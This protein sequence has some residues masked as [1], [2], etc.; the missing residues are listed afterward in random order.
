MVIVDI[1]MWHGP[2]RHAQTQSQPSRLGFFGRIRRFL[3]G[4]RNVADL[5]DDELQR[6]ATILNATPRRCLGYRTPNEAFQHQL[7]ALPQA[8]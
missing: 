3:P 7:A 6:M 8:A 5:A 2:A 1:R 4:D